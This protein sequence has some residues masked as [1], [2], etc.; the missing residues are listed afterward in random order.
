MQVITSRLSL[1]ARQ[2]RFTSS[3]SSLVLNNSRKPLSTAVEPGPL[4]HIRVLDL[5]RIL[6][7]PFATQILGDLG[8]DVIK[9][10]STAGDD[11]RT[12][13]PPFAPTVPD[14]VPAPDSHPNASKPESAY[15]L[16]INRNKRS[17]T[18]NFKTAAGLQMI[19]D[20]AA[21]SDVFVENYIPGKLS[22]MGLGYEDIKKVNPKIIYASVTGY[23][24][25]GPY[26]TRAGYDVM[27]EA[28]AGLMYITGEQDGPPVKV[29]VAITDVCTG[30][31]THGAIMAAL[32]G[33]EMTGEGQWI[34]A[35]LIET[36]V[37]GLANIGHSYL[38]GGK[39]ATRWGTAHESV[40]PYQAFPTSNSYIVV[41][42]GNDKQF[43][44]LSEVFNRMDLADSED[45]GT[46]AGRVKNRKAL[47]PILT[48]CFQTKTTEEWL[49]IFKKN[50][51]PGTPVNNIEQTF[52]HP[53]VIH[54]E[55]IQTVYH[56]KA[57]NIK[58]VGI[59][60]KYGD[61]KPSIRLPPPVLGQHTEEIL[62]D[63]LGKSDKDIQNLRQ[64]GAI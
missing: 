6:A 21:V 17:I 20:L 54:R 62:K 13:G 61:T 35:S 64:E 37:A 5:T 25:D 55:M 57:G 60:V 4:S 27:I 51:L 36:Q 30:L 19:K 39:E 29:G 56:P 33:R 53:Q 23:G 14:Y 59:P 63:V 28:E 1:L 12:W 50:N 40:V 7:G 32:Y 22:E 38:V 46:N 9:V 16:G 43:R 45:Y 47:I 18:C 8:A 11:T 48:K 41:G 31:Y 2:S 58:T 26:A 3:I 34:N 44:R 52:S 10:E 24:P 42:I 15:F 49:G